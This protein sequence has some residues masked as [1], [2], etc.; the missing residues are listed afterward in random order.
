MP[1]ENIKVHYIKFEYLMAF[2]YLIIPKMIITAKYQLFQK[3]KTNFLQK[4]LL[5]G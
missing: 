5:Q 3:I 4:Q 1:D 2:K